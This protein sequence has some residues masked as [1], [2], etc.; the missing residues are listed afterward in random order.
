[1]K[2]SEILKKNEVTISCEISR[3]NREHS[4]R[5]TRQSQQKSQS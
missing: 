5:I 1:M 2:V 3:Q 4:C